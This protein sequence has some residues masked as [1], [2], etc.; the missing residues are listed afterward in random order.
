MRYLHLGPASPLEAYDVIWEASRSYC[1]SPM[2]CAASCAARAPA[3]L[4]VTRTVNGCR[5]RPQ[6]YVGFGVAF[7]VDAIVWA[8]Y[9]GLLSECI[10]VGIP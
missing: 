5:Q 9:I 3:A 8:H 2:L 7:D 10:V 1:D 6:V 4:A